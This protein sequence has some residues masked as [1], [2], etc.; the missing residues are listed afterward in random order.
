[1]K[2]SFILRI[3]AFI[4]ILSLVCVPITLGMVGITFP[5][6]PDPIGPPAA[7]PRNPGFKN[8]F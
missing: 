2:R 5:P 3:H 4:E 8:H 6:L 1:M 7:C